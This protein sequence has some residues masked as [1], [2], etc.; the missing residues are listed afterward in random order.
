MLPFLSLKY[1][2]KIR[3]S[4]ENKDIDEN[5]KNNNLINIDKIE[6]KMVLKI[7]LQKK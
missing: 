1:Q 5:N 4:Y 3:N 7:E 6:K 2:K